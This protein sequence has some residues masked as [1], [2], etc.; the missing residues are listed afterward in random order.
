MSVVKVPQL[1]W[2]EPS[3]LELSFPEA[4]QVETYNYPGYN[5]SEL[6]PEEIK[7]AVNKPIG[8]PRLSEM[9]KGK[10]QV[11][12]A[13]DDQTRITRA[14]KIVPHVLAELKAGGSSNKWLE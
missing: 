6:T 11:V 9:A 10:E 5:E 12:I 7:T 3:E 2:Y 8:S 1:A 4:W 14:A 13:F